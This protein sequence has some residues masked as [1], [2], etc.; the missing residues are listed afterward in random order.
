MLARSQRQ[1]GRQIV[2]ST[3]S[4]DLLEDEG[5]GLDE[6]LLLLPSGKGT[7]MRPAGELSE[8][9]VLLDEGLSM[10]EAVL[11]RTQPGHAEQLA[12]FRH[13]DDSQSTGCSGVVEGEVPKRRQSADI[14][15]DLGC[16]RPAGLA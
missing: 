10:A 4:S 14:D 13:G 11:P 16:H 2:V 5:I 1:T 6:V 8:I 7:E 9:E 3:H 15:S 12:L